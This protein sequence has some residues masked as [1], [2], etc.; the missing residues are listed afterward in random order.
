MTVITST[1]V[2]RTPTDVLDYTHGD[3]FFCSVAGTHRNGTS[4]RR[5]TMYETRIW[6]SGKSAHT[7][8]FR[9]FSQI[10]SHV[11]NHCPFVAAPDCSPATRPG[12]GPRINIVLERSPEDTGVETRLNFLEI[13][14]AE[15]NQKIS[16]KLVRR[17]NLVSR[18]LLLIPVG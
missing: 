12:S 10:L 4:S 18:L 3:V 15:R 9:K 1:N 11:L 17:F 2:F 7:V 8:H 5:L 6:A 13:F 14:N 16:K